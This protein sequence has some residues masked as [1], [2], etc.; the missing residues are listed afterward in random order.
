MIAYHH[1]RIFLATTSHDQSQGVCSAKETRVD[2]IGSGWGS[3]AIQVDPNSAMKLERIGWCSTENHVRGS[4]NATFSMTESLPSTIGWQNNWSTDSAIGVEL[5]REGLQNMSA[6]P[7]LQSQRKFVGHASVHNYQINRDELLGGANQK[8]ELPRRTSTNQDCDQNLDR[9]KLALEIKNTLFQGKAS[10]VMGDNNGK[11]ALLDSEDDWAAF[12]D[13]FEAS[14]SW[15]RVSDSGLASEDKDP[16]FGCNLEDLFSHSW[17]PEAKSGWFRK[18][19]PIWVGDALYPT[20][21]E[22][23][24]RWGYSAKKIARVPEPKPLSKR[25]EAARFVGPRNSMAWET[26]KGGGLTEGNVPKEGLMKTGLGRQGGC[27]T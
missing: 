17:K 23:V 24:R 10:A 3:Q 21:V 15:A 14:P 7:N 27:K 13:L 18:P 2:A 26:R 8:G 16:D 11:G 4:K 12:P 22:D 6:S 5:S 9:V 20:S 1:D 19:K 25:V